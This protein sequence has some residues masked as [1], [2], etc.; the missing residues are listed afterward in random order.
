MALGDIIELVQLPYLSKGDL[1]DRFICTLSFYDTGRW[2]TWLQT[3]GS[4]QKLIEVQAWPAEAFYFGREAEHADDICSNFLTFF[5]QHANFK[6]FERLFSA[7]QDD[8]L[9]LSA[10]FAKLEL[11]FKTSETS[12]NGA[13]RMI[14]TEV[15]YMLLVCRSVFD[16]LQ[17]LVAKIWMRAKPRD[18]AKKKKEL[19]QQFSDM[20]LAANELKT[21]AQIAKQY[22]LPDVIAE[23][24]ARHSPTFLKIRQFRDDLVH[25][26]Y[27]VQMIFHGEKGFVIRKQ[28]GPFRDLDIWRD[29]EVEENGLVP[30]L[31]ALAMV[32]NGTLSACEDFAIT[33]ANCIEFPD[34]IIPGM[35]LY[36]RGYFNRALLAA[37]ADADG[38]L[39]EGRR[40]V[41]VPADT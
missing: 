17:N 30:L 12:R 7:I 4:G 36:M 40:L 39:A 25:R 38:R 32:V 11:I 34:P 1:T 6:E 2:R 20:T 19:K 15:E 18:A 26:G 13:T 35:N 24:Y 41:G 9:N 3:E 33:L 31:P 14:A 23:C 28:L 21:A 5:G 37:L 10:S 29:E 22:Q 16:L 8:I 27:Q